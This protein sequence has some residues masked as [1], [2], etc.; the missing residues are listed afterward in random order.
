[1]RFEKLADEKP[2]MSEIIEVTQLE[3]LFDK[4][5]KKRVYRKQEEVLE[6]VSEA[7]S[8]VKNTGE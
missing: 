5:L 4:M 7:L 3:S 6:Y 8:L 1:M 2:T